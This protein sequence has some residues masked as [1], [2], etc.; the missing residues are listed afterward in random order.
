LNK[1]GARSPYKRKKKGTIVVTMIF[2]YV[3]HDDT[4]QALCNYKNESNLTIHGRTI[5]FRKY[6]L[7]IW[8]LFE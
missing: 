8:G 2:E 7:K 4:P 6:C 1:N 5:K 3:V